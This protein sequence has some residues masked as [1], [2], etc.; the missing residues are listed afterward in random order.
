MGPPFL[1]APIFRANGC[2]RQRTAGQVHKPPTHML[3]VT[4]PSFCL[5]TYHLRSKGNNANRFDC[6]RGYSFPA[7]L[8][9]FAHY[10]EQ[11]FVD[12]RARR[13]S[14]N[15]P[16]EPFPTPYSTT[17]ASNIPRSKPRKLSDHHLV[18]LSHARVIRH[19]S[20]SLVDT[21]QTQYT[22]ANFQIPQ[23]PSIAWPVFSTATKV[24]L[25]LPGFAKPRRS[26][27]RS[28]LI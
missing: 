7:L 4:S 28:L 8:C 23:V 15:C 24:R 10:S 6:I 25:S 2:Q 17:I 13:L 14:I 3:R 11:A 26:V 16:I 27:E 18:L 21:G 9:W 20:F 12:I 1:L 5:R 22:P 19:V